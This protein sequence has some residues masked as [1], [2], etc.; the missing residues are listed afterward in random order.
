MPNKLGLALNQFTLFGLP[1]NKPATGVLVASELRKLYADV[2]DIWDSGHRL[3]TENKNIPIG[4]T[5]LSDRANVWWKVQTWDEN[6][7]ASD[8]SE[9]SVI[10][11]NE[12]FQSATPLR[13]P[14][15]KTGE[16][17][18]EFIDGRHGKALR[19]GL[20]KLRFTPQVIPDFTPAKARR[21]APGFAR[22]TSPTTGSAFT[23][24]RMAR[25]ADCWPSGRKA[26]FGDFG[27]G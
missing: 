8:F 13:R 5:A 15:H 22:K 14:T 23:G 16:G 7:V 20:D 11:I 9:P 24:R 3:S 25:T 2:G 21:S 27:L 4:G 26:R 12:E 17:K 1:K 18:F 6:G 19:F 10:V